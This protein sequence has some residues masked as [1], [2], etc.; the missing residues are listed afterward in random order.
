VPLTSTFQKMLHVVRDA[1][2]KSGKL[3]TVCTEGEQTEIDR[4]TSSHESLCILL[5]GI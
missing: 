4:H 3:V 5:Q 1:A 2:Y